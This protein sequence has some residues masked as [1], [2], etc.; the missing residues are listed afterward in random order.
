M[1]KK[2]EEM[3][4]SGMI[5]KEELEAKKNSLLRKREFK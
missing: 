5:T 4:K 1:I 2:F 3:H